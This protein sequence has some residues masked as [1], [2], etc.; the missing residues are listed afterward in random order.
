[1]TTMLAT[2]ARSPKAI[3]PSKLASSRASVEISRSRRKEL[4]GA[5]STQMATQR[6]SDDTSLPDRL[7]SALAEG[8]PWSDS[9]G[10]VFF[11]A[12]GGGC[13]RLGVVGSSSA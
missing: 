8:S 11:S 7:E 5:S 12:Q 13:W 10:L 4:R 1:M 2:R 9:L 6:I 3:E